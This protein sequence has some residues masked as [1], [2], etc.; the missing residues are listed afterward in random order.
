M[1]HR[2]LLDTMSSGV[3]QNGEETM[4]SI[5]RE[6]AVEGRAMEDPEE[7]AGIGKVDAEGEAAGKAGDTGGDNPDPVVLTFGADSADEVGA[8]EFAEEFGQ[9]GGVVLEVPVEGGDEGGFRGI[10]SGEEGGALATVYLVADT[11]D[12]GK[13][14]DGFLDAAGCEVSAGI[15]D[16]E[17]FVGLAGFG[18]GGGD[19]TGEGEDIIFLIEDRDDDGE[20]VRHGEGS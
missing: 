2:D 4:P 5:E 18:E 7:A 6:D 12:V 8:F 3:D 9:V 17:E 19:L 15:I 20:V 1:V 14:G 10:E 13:L 16:E 11:A